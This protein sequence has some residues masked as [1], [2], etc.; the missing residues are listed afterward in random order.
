MPEETNLQNVTYKQFFQTNYNANNYERKH[1]T[2]WTLTYFVLTNLRMEPRKHSC[3]ASI[4]ITSQ[5]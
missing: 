3:M 4:I 1:D 2:L 5:N